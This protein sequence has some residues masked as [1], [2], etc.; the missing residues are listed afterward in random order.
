MNA[1]EEYEITTLGKNHFSLKLTN[2]STGEITMYSATRVIIPPPKT[3]M[4]KY[5]PTLMMAGMIILQ[6]SQYVVR[7]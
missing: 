7:V 2:R 6:V 4:Q 3:F 1:K 5:G